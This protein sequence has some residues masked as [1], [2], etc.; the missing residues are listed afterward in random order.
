MTT[1]NL[2]LAA[3]LTVLT[4]SVTTATAAEPSLKEIIQD[5]RDNMV[6]ITDGLLYD[7]FDRIERGANGIAQ[8]APIAASQAKRIAEDLGPEMAAFKQFDEQALTSK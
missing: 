1:R 3:S 8:H 2:F 7:E 6:E 5:R 4:L